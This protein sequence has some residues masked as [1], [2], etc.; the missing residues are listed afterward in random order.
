VD[1]VA[2][3]MN[4][5]TANLVITALALRPEPGSDRHGR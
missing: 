3:A 2:V 5:E 4:L 1:D